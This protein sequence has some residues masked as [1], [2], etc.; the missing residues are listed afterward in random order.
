MGRALPVFIKCVK[1]LILLRGGGGGGA[2][3]VENFWVLT[4]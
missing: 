1:P 2:W 4:D 3:K